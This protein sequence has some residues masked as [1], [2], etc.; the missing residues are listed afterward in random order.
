MNLELDTSAA[1]FRLGDRVA[2]RYNYTDE[3][4]PYLHPL[5][6]P[7]GHV[8]SLASP[9]DHKHHKGL[10]YALSVPNV[11][12]WEERPTKPG[13]V[14]GRQ[15]HEQFTSVTDAA[16]TVGFEQTLRWLPSDGGDPIFQETRSISCRHEPASNG[17]A[18]IW[19]AELSALQDTELTMS[20]WSALQADGRLVNY[21]GLGIRFRREF[22][23]TGGNRLLLDGQETPIA[24]GSGT[25][26]RIA[27]FEGSIDG[28]WPVQ[29]A[30][31]RLSQSMGNALFVMDKPFAFMGIGP[32]N[33]GPVSLKTGETLTERYEVLVFDVVSDSE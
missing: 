11:N 21:H 3:F 4:K 15:V 9:H 8:V 30:A 18:W 2:G 19:S 31:V 22:G 5:T 29:K 7:A 1:T 24:E 33:L 26:Y 25:T 13:E 12:F 20:K 10:M 23:C 6:T 32:S 27:E 28:T 14:P 16:E 17:F